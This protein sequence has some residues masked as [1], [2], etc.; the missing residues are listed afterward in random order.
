MRPIVVRAMPASRCTSLVLRPAPIA[1]RTTSGPTMPPAGQPEPSPQQETD[2]PRS[3]AATVMTK[4]FACNASPIGPAGPGRRRACVVVRVCPPAPAFC[5]G[6]AG[7]EGP[8][9]EGQR[10]HDA[11]TLRAVRD[12][13]GTMPGSCHPSGITGSGQAEWRGPSAPDVDRVAGYFQRRQSHLCASVLSVLP[14]FTHPYAALCAYVGPPTPQ[15]WN[16]YAS[17]EPQPKVCG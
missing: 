11:K 6:L 17:G 12:A 16:Q 14:L 9:R 7:T 10:A 13:R 15:E 2:R 5:T 8:G 1:A 4:I 3:A